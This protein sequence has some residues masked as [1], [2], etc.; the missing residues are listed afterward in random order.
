MHTRILCRFAHSLD[1]VALHRGTGGCI[2]IGCFARATDNRL[3][4]PKALREHLTAV[5]A[6]ASV[7]SDVPAIRH[8]VPR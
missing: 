3:P 4:M 6:V 2:C 8:E 5:L 7:A 1:D